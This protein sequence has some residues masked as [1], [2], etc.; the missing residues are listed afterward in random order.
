[1]QKPT[2]LSTTSSI[3]THE[4]EEYLGVISHQIVIGANIFRDVFSSFRDI[5]GGSVKGY[6]KDL[7]KWK[8]IAFEEL[9]DKA[10][11]REANA[12]IGLRIDFEDVSG[13]GKSMFMVSVSATAVKLKNLQKSKSPSGDVKVSFEEVDF[14]IQRNI[15]KQK[16]KN[17]EFE[18]VQNSDIESFIEY[19]VDAGEVVLSR[20]LEKKDLDSKAIDYFRNSTHEPINQY[21]RSSEFKELN[22]YYFTGSRGDDG[23][24][25]FKFLKQI[26]WYDQSVIHHLLQ[27]EEPILKHRALLL[28]TLSKDYY[29]DND[30]DSLKALAQEF[31][32]QFDGFPIK[33]V[34]EKKFGKDKEKWLCLACNTLNSLDSDT[35][36][37]CGAN[38]Y[39]FK[40][41]TLTPAKRSEYLM[42]FAEVLDKKLK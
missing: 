30:I 29:N 3:E 37:S 5:V 42:N 24:T 41:K 23:G 9:I 16:V 20:F 8:G 25:V 22:N 21:L 38:I 26:Q 27:S 14:E 17:D 36:E 11:D 2:L 34:E 40:D 39:G 6:Q 7:E 28:S 1:M 18:Y 32:S 13:G 19:N 33:R 35:C 15:L 10:S 12:L 4:I 31:Q